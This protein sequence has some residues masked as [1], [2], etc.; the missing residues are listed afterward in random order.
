MYQRQPRAAIRT[1]AVRKRP[2]GERHVIQVGIRR[3]DE[4][5]RRAMILVSLAN[6]RRVTGCEMAFAE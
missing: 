2:A 4:R 3:G 1:G 5:P 6:A